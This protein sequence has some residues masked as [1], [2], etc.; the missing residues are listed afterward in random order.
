M[1]EQLREL[2]HRTHVTLICGS[3]RQSL[4]DM[5]DLEQELTRSGHIVLFP[6]PLEVKDHDPFA[7][8]M[9]LARIHFLKDLDWCERLVLA[10]TKPDGTFGISTEREM[11][12][13]HLLGLNVTTVVAR[14]ITPQGLRHYI[15]KHNPGWTLDDMPEWCKESDPHMAVVREFVNV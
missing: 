7:D 15:T 11:E 13:A 6:V 8:A 4:D 10:V 9:H 3:M 1:I 2:L 5:R 12:F 14:S